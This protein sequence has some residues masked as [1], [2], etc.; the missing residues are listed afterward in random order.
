MIISNVEL[1]CTITYLIGIG[2][3][4][5]QTKYNDF[6]FLDALLFCLSPIIIP[7]EIGMYLND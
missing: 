4:I 2:I 3:M 5:K 6:D 1:Y 7:I